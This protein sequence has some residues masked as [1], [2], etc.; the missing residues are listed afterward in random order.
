V[1]GVYIVTYERDSIWEVKGA[2]TIEAAAIDAPSRMIHLNG[3]AYRYQE[4]FPSEVL[5]LIENPSGTIP[6]S[7]PMVMNKTVPGAS[8]PQLIADFR[9]LQD[10][11]Q[12][13]P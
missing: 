6:I 11:A 9:N 12:T 7:R 1:L 13:S 4:L 10:R 3:A 2:V 8:L 5:K